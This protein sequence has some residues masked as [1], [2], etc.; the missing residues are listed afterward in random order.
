MNKYEQK[1]RDTNNKKQKKEI[2]YTNYNIRGHQVLLIQDDQTPIIMSKDKALQLAENKGLDLVQFA[3]SKEHGMGI[4]KIID[5]GK[6]QYEKQ[7]KEKTAKKQARANTV[8]IKTVQFSITTEDNDRER[9]I[10]KA[11]DFLAN[12]DKV[13]LTIRFRNRHESKNIDY[14][15]N[16][17][18]EILSHFTEDAI[19]DSSV[20]QSGRELLCILRPNKKV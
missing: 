12:G 1:N 10:S 18:N 2:I 19:I 16:I 15:K 13:K 20:N 3:Y 17:M 9:L 4:T 14:A 7:K 8:D 5:Y 11:H 6:F